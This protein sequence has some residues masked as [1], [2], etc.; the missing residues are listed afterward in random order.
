M[1]FRISECI[2]LPTHG[3]TTGLC[4][5]DAGQVL[6][7]VE[8]GSEQRLRAVRGSGERT[9]QCRGLYRLLQVRPQP[10]VYHWT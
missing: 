4:N 8:D 2:A 5:F 10:P 7:A 9:L 1:V 6:A 3:K